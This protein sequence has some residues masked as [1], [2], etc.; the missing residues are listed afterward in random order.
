MQA[1]SPKRILCPVDLSRATEQVLGWARL[2]A[3]AFGAQVL[4][5]HAV[6]PDAPAYF[7]PS[8]VRQL[9]REA[10]REDRDLAARLRAQASRLLGKV[11]FEVALRES[12]AVQVILEEAKNADLIVM[13]SHGHSRV[14]RL[15]LGSV[16]E[17]VVRE[18]A[19]PTLIVR[20]DAPQAVGRVLCPVNFTE[21]ARQCME[22]TTAVAETF[23][24]QLDVLQA[25]ESGAEKNAHQRL[26]QWLPD[27]TRRRCQ[28]SEVTLEGDAAEQIVRFA[29]ERQVDLI[30]LGAEHKSFLEFTVFGRTTERVMRYSPAPVLLVP[31]RAAAPA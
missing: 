19:C 6:P 25:V 5:L 13:G 4:V 20:G 27:G 10:Q 31:R 14:A 24:A 22:L 26:C 16:A 29:R 15:L 9:R 17:N 7:L 30:V 23:H 28:V 12:Y 2:F 8:D 1:F 18:A 11:F 21:A 3:E